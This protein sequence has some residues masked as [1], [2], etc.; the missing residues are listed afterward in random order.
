MKY[1]HEA[2]KVIKD[3]YNENYKNTDIITDSNQTNNN[4]NEFFTDVFGNF[5]DESDELEDY[6]QK[7]TVSIKT[8]PL[9]WWKVNILFFNIFNKI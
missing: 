9:Q 3:T 7:P 2:I 6:F 4:L 1:I 8:D 5:N